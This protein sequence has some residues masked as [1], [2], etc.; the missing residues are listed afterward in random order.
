MS[1]N[2]E[3]AWNKAET[4]PEPPRQTMRNTDIRNILVVYH[5]ADYPLRVAIYDHLHCFRRYSGRNCVYL[6]TAVRGPDRLISAI[7]WDLIVFHTLFLSQRWGREAFAEL[8]DRIAP[9]KKLQGVKIALPQDE[10][11]NTDL[12]CN[13]INEFSVDYVFSVAPESEW[14]KIYDAVDRNKVLFNRVLTGYLEEKTIKRLNSGIA[15]NGNRTIDIGYRAWRPEPWLGRHGMLK[16]EIADVFAAAASEH[17]ISTDISTRSEDTLHG[18][19]WYRFLFDCKYTIGVEGGA[20]ILDRDGKLSRMTTE[21]VA[22]HPGASFEEVEEHVFP[23]RDGT[24]KLF[25]LSPRHLEACATKTCQILVEGE[26][27]GVLRPNEHFIPLNKD[28]SNVH[29]VLSQVEND[30]LREKTT[31][32]AYRDIVSS[33]HYTYSEF[34]RYV[35]TIVS[36]RAQKQ[37]RKAVPFG[38]LLFSW[39]RLLDRVCWLYIA[40]LRRVLPYFSPKT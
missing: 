1:Q 14:E 5:T 18:D 36:S 4:L 30:D 7:D 25:A 13:F 9:L 16:A 29:Q 33:G 11:L 37:T 28:F 17:K 35:M 12:L 2:I 3:I 10:F 20:S 34:V 39:L 21:Y 38:F 6:N 26:Y 23:G 22:A 19:R 8:L 32:R 31:E 27:N 15:R 24:F 40:I